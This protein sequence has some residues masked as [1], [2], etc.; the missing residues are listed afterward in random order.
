MA[1][2]WIRLYRQSTDNPLYHSD[3]FDRWHAWQDLLLLVNHE[4][5][6]FISKGKLMELEPG[7]T[8][9]SLPILADRWQWSVNRV[10]RYLRLLNDMGMCISHGT[11]YGTSITV[12]NWAKYQGRGQGDGYGNGMAD[13]HADEY[14]DGTLTR[15]YK[16]DKE[17]KKVASPQSPTDEPDPHAT[18]DEGIRR[19]L[20]AEE[21]KGRWS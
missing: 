8:I 12:V 3:P 2:G 10:R 16:N 13:G 9:T 1:K 14:A 18:D 6:Q 4:K 19:W 17:G 15:I 5:K 20:E 11:P 7:Q 21:A